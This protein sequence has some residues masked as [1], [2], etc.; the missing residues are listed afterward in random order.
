[1]MLA[2]YE[3]RYGLKPMIH[4]VLIDGYPYVTAE[5][6][7]YWGR[8]SGIVKRI[9]VSEPQFDE[10]HKMWVVRCEVE[11]ANGETFSDIGKCRIDEP[12]RAD[13]IDMAR[14]RAIRRTLRLAVPLGLD[15]EEDRAFSESFNNGVATPV[16][17]PEKPARN[18]QELK[19][20]V[21]GE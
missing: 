3:V 10:K 19:R 1:V 7:R 17:V 14:T 5:G 11:T 9:S 18:L 16:Q 8:E 20:E 2:E 15:E 13:P 4:V 21:N 12:T 6:Y